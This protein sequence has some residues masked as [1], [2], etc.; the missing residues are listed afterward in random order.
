M[1]YPHLF[2]SSPVQYPALL[3]LVAPRGQQ[4]ERES[5]QEDEPLARSILGWQFA[6]LIPDR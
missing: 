3:D 1:I 5:L 6:A 4:P 2:E